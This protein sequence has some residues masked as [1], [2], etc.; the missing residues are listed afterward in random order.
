MSRAF[1]AL[2]SNLGEPLDQLQRAAASIDQL[3]DSAVI[4][5]S[6]AYRSSAVGPGEQP[7]YLNAVL[8]LETTLTP[9]ALLTALQEIESAQGRERNLR[10]GAR[11]LDLDILLYDQQAV[12]S[13]HLTI[14][15]PR[16]KERNFVLYPLL[17][18]RQPKLMLP[19][20]AELGT[21]VGACPL[22][23][24]QK[25]TFSLCAGDG[26]NTG[27]ADQTGPD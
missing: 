22:G 6:S 17:E 7:D 19:D 9:M 4:Q 8:L 24:L 26:A 13:L 12:D 21:L 1:I 18:I 3:P 14:P 25:T 23:K 16:M 11:T 10:W 20:G 5:I 2:G 15:H 27:N